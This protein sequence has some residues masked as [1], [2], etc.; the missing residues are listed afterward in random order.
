[1]IKNKEK[2]IYKSQELGNNIKDIRQKNNYTQEEFSEKIGI[3]PQF[4]SSV[5]RGLVGISLNT[6]I[7]ICNVGNCSSVELFKNIIDSNNI[8]D[9]YELLNDR[10][11][12][13]IKH[14]ISY[15]LEI[16]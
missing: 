12:S 1:M 6:A 13:I 8:N 11:K 4:L 3:T 14:M 2:D 16:G 7:K 10:D 9:I 15:L 5:E